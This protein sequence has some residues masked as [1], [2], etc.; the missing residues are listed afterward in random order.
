MTASMFDLGSSPI[1]P[2]SPGGDSVRDDARYDQLEGF[3]Q[4]LDAIPWDEVVSLAS[5]LLAQQGKDVKVAA[6]LGV[7]LYEEREWQGLNDAFACWKGLLSEEMWGHVQPG[8]ARS[9][10][11]AITWFA[12]RVGDKVRAATPAE[13]DLEVLREV[14]GS[15]VE[16][17]NLVEER[18]GTNAPDLVSVA[19]LLKEHVAQ[20]E[21]D[22]GIG[23]ATDNGADLADPFAADYSVDPFAEPSGDEA[24]AAEEATEVAAP[25]PAEDAAPKAKAD[26]KPTKTPKAPKV[27]DVPSSDADLKEGLQAF[28]KLK[29]PVLTTLEIIRRGAPERPSTYSIAREWVWSLVAAPPA[30]EGKTSI[31]SPGTRDR[32]LWDGMVSRSDWVDLLHSA[33]GRWPKT[34]FWLDPH[35]YVA[36]A[37]QEL[38]LDEAHD[39]VA[40]SVGALLERIPDLADLEFADGTPLADEKTR[41]WISKHA[42]SGGSSLTAASPLSLAEA[43]GEDDGEGFEFMADVEKLLNKN[44]FGEAVLGF[45]SGLARVPD[46]R[47][48]FSLKLRFAQQL[49]EA[50]RVHVARPML[51]ALDEEVRR[52]DLENW[53]PRLAAHVIQ[54][55]LVAMK[56]KGHP[57]AKTSDFA[58]SVARLRVRLA[59]LG[60][61]S[62]L[63]TS[64]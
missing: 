35:F 17:E 2:E 64:K 13:Q 25:P 44:K 38:G 16:F 9:R 48:R 7:G 11:T 47:A 45:E 3:F 42:S 37:L 59:R 53:E 14:Q 57:D 55:L 40:A 26:K 24:D 60:S 31:P 52:F 41:A 5:D 1:R 6:R 8:R 61:L 56:S 30:S 39:A 49:L 58:Q 4:G 63:E 22:L 12:D 19:R 29:E 34:V 32:V 36:T 21:V 50:D 15:A 18:M 43:S 51:E 62:V 20:L 27:P 28:K 10:A 33:E 54:A 46:R 23:A